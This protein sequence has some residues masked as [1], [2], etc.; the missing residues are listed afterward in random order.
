LVPDP[1]QP[2]TFELA[3]GGE[4][5]VK[6]V[7]RLAGDTGP[8]SGSLIASHGGLEH[9][10]RVVARIVEA[11][12]SEEKNPEPSPGAS[13]TPAAPDVLSSEEQAA[14]AAR[15]PSDFEYRLEP[16]WPSATAFV[17]WS[18]PALGPVDFQIEVL[19]PTRAGLI[20][21]SPFQDRLQIP[22]EIPTP[23][24]RD[25]WTPVSSTAAGIEKLPDGRWQARVKDLGPGFHRIRVVATEP[26]AK[27]A[28]GAELIIEVGKIP[29]PS[30]LRWIL[31][32]LLIVSLAYLLRKRLP[33]L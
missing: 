3:P 10:L 20:D 17:S 8:V 31:A 18:R 15:L 16:S 26:G 23:E 25:E 11:E 27:R 32:G 7:W 29:L 12:T 19:R 22:G 5:K 21:A 4:A 1:E 28:D 14:L 30:V 9:T 24:L 13:T 33:R 6:T 2:L